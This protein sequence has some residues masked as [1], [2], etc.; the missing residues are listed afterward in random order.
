[1]HHGYRQFD[2]LLE[3]ITS[4]EGLSNLTSV[5]GDLWISH[6]TSL[7]NLNGLASLTSV[8]SLYIQQNPALTNLNGLATLT[9]LELLFIHNND[10]LTN[11]NAL[12]TLTSVRDISIGNNDALTNLNALA[13][14]TTV[15]SLEIGGNNALTN[16][17]SLAALSSVGNYLSIGG[18]S[19]LTSLSGLA[20]LTRVGQLSISS[21]N[22]L[23]DLNGLAALTSVGWLV[24]DQ[25]LALTNLNGLA[26]L[27]SLE[28]LFIQRN[29]AL[30]DINALATLTSAG[31]ISIAGNDALPNLNAL[32]ALTSVGRLSISYS[33]LT[34]LSGL[35]ALTSVV[36]DLSIGGNSALTSLSG[37][38]SLTSVGAL[39][40]SGNNVLTDLNGLAALTSVGQLVIQQNPA[41]TNLN[42]LAALTSLEYL[43][44]HNNGALTDINALATLTSVGD[45]SIGNNDVLTDL[46]GLSALVSVDF[47]VS[48]QS[49]ASLGV[50]AGLST[51]LD[52]IDDG[53]PGPGP[54]SAGIPDVGEGVFIS[55]NLDG[56]NTVDEILADAPLMQINAGLNDAWFNP[57]TDGQGFFVTVFPA[58]GVVFLSWFTYDT[59]LPSEDATAN[60]GDPGHRWLT[61]QGS[62]AGNQAVL[63]VTITSGGIFDSAAEISR[64]E[65]GTIILT[66]DDCTAGTVE[67]D[68]PSINQQG[69]VPIQ[70]VVNDNVALCENLGSQSSTNSETTQQSSSFLATDFQMNPGLND[71]WFYLLTDGQGFF[72]TVFPESE[73]VFL[74][75]FT[76]DTSLPAENA[77]AKLG[78]PGHRWLTAQGV[79]AG[80]QSV[81]DITFTTGGIFDSADE[82]H[83]TDPPGSDGTLTLTFEDCYSGTVEY[84]IPSIN[85]QG[86]VPII[87]VVNDN[88]ALCEA[89]LSP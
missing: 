10:A 40:I 50:C 72:I 34:N 19:A 11:F 42:G 77:T 26:A 6:N 56:C 24:I 18:N 44:I 27:T 13:A 68:I 54:G 80:N 25:N 49:N 8:G 82:V 32:A 57:V 5:G 2:A 16:L 28:L 62:Y 73:V 20:A 63:D 7:T 87:R 39:A 74:S 55:N 14:L 53:V 78:D 9:S 41:L 21:N 86:A 3:V 79:Y 51:L 89:F 71:A 70:R 60:L 81:M 83:R 46:N 38:S 61:A 31:E 69:T 37:L 17:N 45:I 67:Y 30:T 33:T 4:L 43:F 85:Q 58:S 88:V 48:L 75:W 84:D 59:E 66:F 52:D 47:N 36:N 23:T 15:E 35:A 22:V 76:Y 65:D 12:A 64:V 1:M 29:P